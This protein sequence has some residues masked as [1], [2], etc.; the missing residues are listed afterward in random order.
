MDTQKYMG[1][2]NKGLWNS[3]LIATW[4][5]FLLKALFFY[6]PENYHDTN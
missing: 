3:W 1:V 4:W 6:T 5:R 2:A